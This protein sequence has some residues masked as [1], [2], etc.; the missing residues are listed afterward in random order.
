MVDMSFW[1][2]EEKEAVMVDGNVAAVQ[3]SEGCDIISVRIVYNLVQQISVYRI[4]FDISRLMATYVAADDVEP[5]CV[6]S[7]CFSKVCHTTPEVTK[8]MDWRRT[9][10]LGV[11]ISIE[12]R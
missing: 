3:A 1:S 8:L 10:Y 7:I 11:S 2:L 6:E 5:R 12:K 4:A 9:C